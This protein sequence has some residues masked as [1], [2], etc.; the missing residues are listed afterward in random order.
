MTSASILL[1]DDEEKFVQ[2]NAKLLEHRGYRVRTA[3]NGETAL[4]MLGKNEADVVILDIRMPGMDGISV[5]TEIK[6]RFPMVEV[7]LLSGQATF[8]TAVQ[9]LK[10]GAGDYLLK[11]CRLDDLTKKIEEALEKHQINEEKQRYRNALEKKGQS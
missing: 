9:G 7:I 8:E 4:R 5:L 1:V 2:S 10:L 11:P 3:H 6:A